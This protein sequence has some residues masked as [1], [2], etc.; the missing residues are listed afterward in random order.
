MVYEKSLLFCNFACNICS[1]IVIPTFSWF[2]CDVYTSIYIYFCHR[3]F[4]LFFNRAVATVAVCDAVATTSTN[5]P[6]T[7]L[8]LFTLFLSLSIS[9]LFHVGDFQVT[10]VSVYMYSVWCCFYIFVFDFI[11]TL[12]LLSSSWFKLNMWIESTTLCMYYDVCVMC[13]NKAF[14]RLACVLLSF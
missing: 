12:S 1:R 14:N 3:N 4:L 11:L 6:P 13:F 8:H 5:A 10:Q 9:I 7:F 2:P